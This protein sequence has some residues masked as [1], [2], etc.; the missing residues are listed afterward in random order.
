MAKQWFIIG[1]MAVLQPILKL[2]FS[3]FIGAGRGF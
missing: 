3:D 1:N 2:K